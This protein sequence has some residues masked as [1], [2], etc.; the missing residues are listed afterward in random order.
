MGKAMAPAPPAG[1]GLAAGLPVVNAVLDRLGFDAI[2]SAGLPA[3]GRA[4]GV[5]AAAVVGVLVRNLA[6]GRE[7][8]YGLA[9]W[10]GRFDEAL[11]GLRAGPAARLNDDRAG[12]AL[13]E[14]YAA[15]RATMIT[16]LSV[17]AVTGFGVCAAELHNDSTSLALY[18]AYR[19]RP[20]PPGRPAPPR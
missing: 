18:G 5:A 7:P 17:A 20:A 2:V 3:P 8:L 6:L 11:L 9:E 1:P 16:A 4:R 13:D 14:L 12:R 19:D 15:D 10:A